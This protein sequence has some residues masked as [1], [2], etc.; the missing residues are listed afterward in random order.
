MKPESTHTVALILAGGTGDRIQSTRPK[1]FLE[2]D[3]VPVIAR[4]MAAFQQHTGIESVAVVCQPQ[5]ADYVRATAAR[6]GIHKLTACID[7][8][9]SG[10]ESLSRGVEGLA[11]L[12]FGDD[13]IVLVHDAVRPL[14]SQRIITGNIETCRRCGNAITALRCDEALAH[15]SDGNLV[16]SYMPRE[17]KYRIQTP[18]TFRL[19]DILKACRQ[20]ATGTSASA[21]QSLYVLMAAQEDCTLHMTAGETR[22]FKLTYPEDI[23]FY[24]SIAK[25]ECL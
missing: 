21:P 22:N 16:E 24:E 15:S 17:H 6:N 19:A 7:G 25:T 1:Q 9:N 3:G 2:I 13:T 10:F 8:G 18:H 4:T 20:A 11:S 5:W 12:G 14:V 23:V